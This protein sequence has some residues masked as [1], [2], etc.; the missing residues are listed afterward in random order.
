MKNLKAL[1]KHL[2]IDENTLLLAIREAVSNVGSNT[3]QCI[4][5]RSDV[6]DDLEKINWSSINGSWMTV[7]NYLEGI[8]VAPKTQLDL[9]YTG[10][11]LRRFGAKF[12][13]SNGKNLY[14]IPIKH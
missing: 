3:D 9:K 14:F 2:D 6:N 1:A 8:N 4:F 10:S 7:T 5:M 12:R 11:Q 13:R